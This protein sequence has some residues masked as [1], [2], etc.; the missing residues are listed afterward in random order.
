M[1]WDFVGRIRE[2]RPLE[3]GWLAAGAGAAA[4]VIV[5]YRESGIG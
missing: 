5:V 4:P 2:L 1:S 3:A